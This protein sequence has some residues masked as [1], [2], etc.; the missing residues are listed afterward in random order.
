MNTLA[1]LSSQCKEESHRFHLC[2][3]GEGIIKID[4]F[5][6]HETT[7]HKSSLVLDDGTG[8][9]PLQPEHPLKGDHA[10][11]TREVSKLLG[12]VLL[13]CVHL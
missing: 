3:G 7:C 1:F 6:L 2:H 13:N 5:L 4:A 9:I 10:V 8:F 12:M 11:T